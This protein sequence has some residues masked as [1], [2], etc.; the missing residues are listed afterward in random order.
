VFLIEPYKS[1]YRR[2]NWRA[3]VKKDLEGQLKDV[4]WSWARRVVY[5]DRKV[6]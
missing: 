5:D 3:F 4:L 6:S 1:K 2:K